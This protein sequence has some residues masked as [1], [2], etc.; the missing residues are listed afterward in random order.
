VETHRDGAALA[1]EGHHRV[2][3]ARPA[4]GRVDDEPDGLVLDE[5]EQRGLEHVRDVAFSEDL[6]ERVER[7]AGELGLDEV[8]AVLHHDVQLAVALLALPGRDEVEHVHA[9]VGLAVLLALLAAELDG[10]GHEE[11]AAGRRVLHLDEAR[12]EVDLG[13][14]RRDRDEGR[15]PDAEDGRDGLVEEALVAVRGFLQNQNVAAGALGRADL[16]EKTEKIVRSCCLFAA[17]RIYGRAKDRGIICLLGDIKGNH[18]KDMSTRKQVAIVTHEDFIGNAVETLLTQIFL[19]VNLNFEIV[20]LCE[21]LRGTNGKLTVMSRPYSKQ[22]VNSVAKLKGVQ[23]DLLIILSHGVK[24]ALKSGMPSSACFS[25]DETK[26]APESLKL[27]ACDKRVESDRGTLV[28]LPGNCV[29]LREVTD[30][31]GLAIVLCCHGND[32]LEDFKSTEPKNFTDMLVCNREDMDN[33][34]FCLFFVMLLNLIDSDKQMRTSKNDIHVAVKDHIRT[35]FE[36]VKTF[37]L[38]KDTFWK[39]LCDKYFVSEK[40]S[41]F[42][43][44]G[45]LYS[46]VLVNHVE[47]FKATIL[48]DFQALTLVCWD[49]DTGTIV[50]ETCLT[51]PI[52]P[53]Q[54]ARK[55]L[56]DEGLGALLQS[57]R[58]VTS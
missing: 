39:F 13:R 49:D 38:N 21:K 47:D 24:T 15:G 30:S 33:R 46:F 18:T 36:Y 40:G 19:D 43:V 58:L 3:A 17:A 1:D 35:I 16:R 48:Q 57:L 27:W 12:V 45:V 29:T 26:V 50:E 10:A 20:S 37:G 2:V 9:L 11:R 22:I 5:R 52:L 28:E 31:S 32:I 51:E 41:T 14:E 55:R 6:L 4:G 34:S 54:I 23:A 8:R 25:P 7:E 53:S 42:R 44:F 56:R